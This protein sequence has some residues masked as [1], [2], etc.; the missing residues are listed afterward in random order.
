[1][2]YASTCSRQGQGIRLA[3]D[4]KLVQSVAS[5]RRGRVVVITRSFP[6]LSETFVVDHVRAL[7]QAG[8]E[9]IVLA[10][11]VDA[12]SLSSEFGA[13]VR[14]VQLPSWS[15][16]GVPA[17]FNAARHAAGWIR[18]HPAFWR[19][20]IAWKRAFYAQRLKRVLESLQPDLVH[21]HF[22]PHGVDAAIALEGSA[23]PL[24]VDFHGYD[25]TSFTQQHGWDLYRAVLGAARLV[26]HSSFVQRVLAA[27]GLAQ[28]EF[29]VMGVDRR[30]FAGR[31]R[32]AHWEAPLRMVCVGRLYEKKG[33]S[34]AIQALAVLRERRPDLDVRLRIIGDGPQ[35]ESLNRLAD[36]LGVSA[37]IT[38]PAPARQPEVAVA[39][40]EAD[41]ALVPSRIMPDGWQE[42]F[43]RVAIEA[44]S[45]GLPVVA[46]RSGGLPDT[47]GDGGVIA[48]REDASALADATIALLSEMGPADW[49]L[50]A[51]KSA[52]RFDIA[53]MYDGYQ[54]LT[55]DLLSRDPVTE[56]P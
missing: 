49:A 39:L 24:V 21:A 41:L 12:R 30:L 14:A 46:T 25:V 37:F 18:R 50:R 10:R 7:L 32:P 4:D 3:I 8:H 34:L 17:L 48:A 22:G 19:S 20:R 42:S 31:P 53:R 26:A 23:T 44:M 45:A 35:L 55:A 51:A 11:R 16:L 15:A 1:M 38:G 36:S 5:R 29:V 43:C 47:V 28:S 9:V 2:G 52:A 13:G 54:S 56:Q 6:R 40:L 27:Q 33:Q